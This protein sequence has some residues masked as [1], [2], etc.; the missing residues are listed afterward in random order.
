MFLSVPSSI[1][2]YVLEEEIG[3]GS[4]GTVYSALHSQTGN[5]FAIKIVPKS[6]LE[7]QEDEKRFQREINAMAYLDHPH[8]VHLKDFLTD[9]NNFYLV[10][11]Y[12]GGKDLQYYIQKNGKMSEEMASIVF[13]QIAHALMF[14]H[15]FGIAHRDL[16]PANIMITKFPVVKIT[17]FGL[18]GILAGD[19][20]MKNFCGSPCYCAPECLS[21]VTYNGRVSDIWSLGVI[22]Y[23]MVTGTP[24]WTTNNLNVMTRQI[25]KGNFTVPKYV[26][27]NCRSLI[28][29]MMRVNPKDRITLDTIL[30]D[31]FT[32]AAQIS[33]LDELNIPIPPNLPISIE[34]V[35]EA[36]QNDQASDYGIL[37]PFQDDLVSNDPTSPRILRMKSASL[38]DLNFIDQDPELKSWIQPKQ[39]DRTEKRKNVS[40]CQQSQM[41]IPKPRRSSQYPEN[42]ESIFHEI[43]DSM[44]LSDGP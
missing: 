38:Q 21:R 10:M 14:S 43:D 34:D 20:L 23:Q 12:C 35:S 4:F 18:C 6:N 9:D 37:S 30:K 31:P 32:A 36:S 1:G 3:S 44:I 19:Q 7:S 13:K 22:L 15:S 17:D 39:V 42:H 16:K 33:G 8:V 26:S 24:P 41:N 25:I 2:L 11:D 40:I 5:K 29:K 28:M 27:S